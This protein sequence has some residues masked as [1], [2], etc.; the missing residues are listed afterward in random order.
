[1]KDIVPELL[2]EI[3]TKFSK[4]YDN[5]Q[6]IQELLDLLDHKKATYKH[7]NEFA[8]ILGQILSNALL[9]SVTTDSLPDGRMYYNIG[10]RLLE[11][12]LGNN[13]KIITDYTNDVQSTLNK[14]AGI[15]LKI[16]TPE[17]NQDRIDGLVN[18]LDS[19]PDFDKVK[20]MLGEP[21]VNF[22][23]SIIDDSIKANSEQHYK[24]G[25][26]PKIVR[27][28][29]G[30]CCEWCQSLV[31][32]YTY[33]DVPNDVYRRHQNCRCTVDYKTIDGKRKNVWSKKETIDSKNKREQR[34][35]MN[36]DIRD[37]NRKNDINEYKEIISVLGT[38]NSPISLAKFQDLKYN[39]VERYEQLKDKVYIQRNFKNGTWLDKINPEKQARHI[40]STVEEGKSYFF[41]DVD[42]DMLY[43]KYKMSGYIEKRKGIR[44]QLEKIDLDEQD[45][46]GIDTFSGNRINAMTIHYSKTGV[47]L[48]PT[49]YERRI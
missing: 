6:E 49:Y 7:A 34:R 11:S 1:M 4:H 5:N 45:Y 12:T 35:Q 25:L 18:R 31:G 13:H 46:L 27:K 40:Q 21:I 23:Q 41:D 38:E 8:I 44:T 17:L 43:N 26:T 37:N 33:P 2:S 10:K 19:E 28:A 14:K 47:H 36:I 16:A 29:S 15:N 30:H 3:Q 9:G 42:F 48:V 39:D 22:S 24:V 32:S 20:W